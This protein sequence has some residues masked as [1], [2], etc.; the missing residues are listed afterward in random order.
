MKTPNFK[1]KD[2][3]SLDETLSPIILAG[4]KK[5]KEELLKDS[6][7]SFPSDMLER[8]GAENPIDP[9]IEEH[10]AAWDMW[11][12]VIDK[13]IFAFDPSEEPSMDDYGFE[14]EWE[15]VPTKEG[16]SR[17]NIDVTDKSEYDRFH[18][19]QDDWDVKCREGRVLFAE[20][21]HNLWL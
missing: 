21:F 2:V 10:A 3:I 5:F 9:T 11:L 19:D 6:F 14:F 7:G 16:F 20:F 15:S 4:L 17:M 12:E 8:I 13:M 18:N 1:Y